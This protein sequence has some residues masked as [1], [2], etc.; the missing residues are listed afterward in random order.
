V[1]RLNAQY[2]P[3]CVKWL[4]CWCEQLKLMILSNY[5][6][7]AVLVVF[8]QCFMVHSIINASY[9]WETGY[10]VCNRIILLNVSKLGISRNV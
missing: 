8:I 9:I 1:K 6:V 3:Q 4:A 2:L 5:Y 10:N 7:A